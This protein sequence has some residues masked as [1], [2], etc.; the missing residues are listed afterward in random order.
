MMGDDGRWLARCSPTEVGSQMG[1]GSTRPAALPQRR[2]IAPRLRRHK[3]MIDGAKARMTNIAGKRTEEK[4]S[5]TRNS[6][7]NPKFS[8]VTDDSM[9]AP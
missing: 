9:T 1:W 4:S 5:V 8:S 2:W 7:P 3:A 6:K